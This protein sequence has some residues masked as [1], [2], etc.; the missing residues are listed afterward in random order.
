[1]ILAV[2]VGNTNVV[3][4]I[5]EGEEI[6]F[7]ERLS[8]DVKATGYEYAVR[9]RDALAL[10]GVDCSALSGGIISSVVP[11]VTAALREAFRL[12]VDF[13]PIV[14]R[15]GIKTDLAIR[16]DD[17]AA[18]GSDRIVDAVAAR[19]RYPL[20]LIVLDMGTANTVS[21]LNERGE[22]LGGVIMPG[23][24]LSQDALARGTSLLPQ[25]SMDPP[26]AVIGKN[27]VDSMR[28]GLFLG[29]ASTL[30]GIFRRIEE[31]LGQ[32]CTVVATGGLSHLVVPL[33]RREIHCDPDL[34]LRGLAILYQ[35]N[36]LQLPPTFAPDA[37]KS[38]PLG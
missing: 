6:R 21:V 1:M 11:P 25:V 28:S 36:S 37:K 26:H 30:D 22:F 27:T 33:C 8:T 19:A 12:L 15:P 16:T 18:V 35:M 9:L 7:V 17:P 38:S 24:R 14:V 13:E 4:G 3:L 23:L 31:E 32:S 5:L 34:L 10:S 20:P 2:D 29:C